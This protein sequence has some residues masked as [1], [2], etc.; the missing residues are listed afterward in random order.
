MQDSV[1]KL[2]GLE[3]L[4]VDGAPSD[5]VIFVPQRIYF[6]ENPNGSFTLCDGW[7][8]DVWRVDTAIN[9]GDA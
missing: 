6:T 1:I 9:E 5:A 8:R 2:A 4:V 7:E 3:V